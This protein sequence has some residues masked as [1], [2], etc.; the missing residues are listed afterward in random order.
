M[1]ALSTLLRAAARAGLRGRSGSAAAGARG[2]EAVRGLCAHSPRASDCVCGL[3]PCLQPHC[4]ATDWAAWNGGF[5]ADAR[6][7]APYQGTPDSVATAMLSLAALRPGET[8][9]DLG[10]GDGR[11]LLTAV[12]RFDAG[13]AVGWE[14]DGAVH[15]IAQAHVAARLGQARP[16]LAARIELNCGDA[17]D[18]P[19]AGAA[20][21]ALYLLP[22]GHAVL[23]P[24]LAEQLPPG[25]GARVVAHGWPVPGWTPT[26]EV[27]TTMGTRL[28]LYVR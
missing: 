6:S 13:R 4:F 2:R 9:V 15:A 10:S 27:A 1:S 26:R 22:E 18:A 20:V 3:S 16:D 21:V 28:Y 8:F 14:L 25:C 12:E 5:T 11:V 17:R 24:H 23:A 19:L 7:L